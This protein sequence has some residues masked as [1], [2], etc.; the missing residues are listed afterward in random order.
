MMSPAPVATAAGAFII[1]DP[2]G[3]RRTA[4]FISSATV[5]YI[6]AADEDGWMQLPSF[7]LGGTFAAGACGT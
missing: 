5:Q 4:L 6:Y 2:S 1:K 3:I 7:A